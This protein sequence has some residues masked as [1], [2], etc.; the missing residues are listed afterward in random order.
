MTTIR[1]ER[2]YT[3]WASDDI[4]LPEGIKFDDIAGYYVKWESFF[5][6]LHGD[7]DN[8]R[9]VPL[10]FDPSAMDMKRPDEVDV[11]DVSEEYEQYEEESVE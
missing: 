1:V 5:Y 11:V 3:F 4:E 6:W 2:G 9:E 8:V 7:E 10:C